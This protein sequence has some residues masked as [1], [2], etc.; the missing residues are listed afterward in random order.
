VAFLKRLRAA[1]LV[2]LG[3]MWARVRADAFPSSDST[4][5]AEPHRL[6]IPARA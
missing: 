1:D 4:D 5:R 3:D 6:P 2:A